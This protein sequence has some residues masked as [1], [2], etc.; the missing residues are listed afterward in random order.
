[1][2]W[3][4]E[5]VSGANRTTGGKGFP[6]EHVVARPVSKRLP[7]RSPNTTK[8]QLAEKTADLNLVVLPLTAMPAFSD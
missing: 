2:V 8:G 5:A 6:N 7:G 3:P 4:L 1:M